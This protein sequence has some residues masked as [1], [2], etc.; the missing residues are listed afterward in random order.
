MVLVDNRSREDL[1][2]AYRKYAQNKQPDVLEML[3]TEL[4]KKRAASG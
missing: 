3:E 2:T 1:N 4:D